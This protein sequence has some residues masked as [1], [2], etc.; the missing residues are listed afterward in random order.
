M[1]RLDTDVIINAAIQVRRE[2]RPGEAEMLLRMRIA[3]G[4]MDPRL[5]W[6]L[7]L[8][9]LALRRFGEAWEL[10]DTRLVVYPPPPLPFPAWEGQD[11]AG[12]A[13]LV[14]GEP[15]LAAQTAF[16]PQ[17]SRLAERGA[18]VTFLC[19]PELVETAKGRGLRALAMVGTVE[20]PDP[21]GW[22]MQGSIPVRL[23]G[24]PGEAVFAW[25]LQA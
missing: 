5:Q 1:S 13:I 16:L 9:L 3:E 24:D 19:A 14:V 23:G 10:F 6:Q 4:A 2:G 15:D 18:D 12:R 17:V 21:D 25:A 11:P 22:L 8:A 20:F 7:A